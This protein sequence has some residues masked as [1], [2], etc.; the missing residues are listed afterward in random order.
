MALP[1]GY[2][3]IEYIQGNGAAYINT[4]V[5]PTNN[6]RVVCTVS[7]WPKSQI[8][9]CLF[10]SRT[11]TSATNRFSIICTNDSTYRS[12]YYNSNVTLTSFS[13]ITSEPTIIDKNKNVTSISTSS[14]IYTNTSGK[15]SGTYPLYI[16][17]MNTGGT[18][19]LISTAARVWS[20]LIYEN[21]VLIRKYIPCQDASGV[22]GLWDDVNSVFYKSIGSQ[23]FT[24]GPIIN[25]GGVFVNVNGAWKSI[26]G[27]T[28]NV[29]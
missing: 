22:A 25:R 1:S 5:N 2:K 11:S 9:T 13:S 21:D 24:S 6:T 10:G 18:I 17:A 20:V 4:N 19:G 15:F 26:D 14:T 3:E 28:V 12:D 27:I 23:D 8:N 16:L 29:N 7:N